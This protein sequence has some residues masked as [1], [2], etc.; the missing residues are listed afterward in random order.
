MH[1]SE[2]SFG[3]H[4]AIALPMQCICAVPLRLGDIGWLMYADG[5]RNGNRIRLARFGLQ[6]AEETSQSSPGIPGDC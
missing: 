6:H 3:M 2:L 1:M 4:D 5:R